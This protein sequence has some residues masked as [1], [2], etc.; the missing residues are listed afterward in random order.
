[1]SGATISIATP[2]GEFTGYLA[3]PGLTGTG[4][5]VV[6]LQEIFGVNTNMRQV[7][8]ALAREGFT[9]LCPDLF[10]RIAPG[11][12][13]TDNTQEE[14][15]RAFE[16][17]QAFDVDAGIEDIGAAIA[18]LRKHEACTGKVGAVGY[19]LGGLLAFLTGAR[20]DVDAAVGYYGVGIQDRLGE[21]Q[22]IA[23]PLM[24][25][26]AG[27]DE[28]VPPEAQSLITEGLQNHPDV[29]LHH[30]PERDHAFTRIGGAHYDADDAATAN[31][32]T[33]T[34]FQTHLA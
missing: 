33:R 21:A 17:Y 27:K 14:W 23:S 11:I 25:H 18:T 19:C 7:C 13:L 3:R 34:F 5:G 16:L 22:R 28:F 20:T 1:M 4:P 24:L 12:S 9:A 8:D 10:W 15:G 30:Y 32:R 29:T 31:E 26:I 6:V 2:D